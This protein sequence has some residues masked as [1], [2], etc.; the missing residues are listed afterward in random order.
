MYIVLVDH[1]SRDALS[2]CIVELKKVFTDPFTI[3]G[4]EEKGYQLR[5]EGVGDETSP[6]AHAKKFLKTWKPKPVEET[7]THPPTKEK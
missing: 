1:K 4:S 5:L 6:R 3:S 7:A 2:D